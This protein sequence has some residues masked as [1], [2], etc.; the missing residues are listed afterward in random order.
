MERKW[1]W[2]ELGER[3]KSSWKGGDREMKLGFR[4]GQRGFTLIELMV[5]MAIL[6]VLAAVVI[7]AVSGTTDVSEDASVKSDASAVSTAMNNY[8]ADQG[9][10]TLTADTDALYEG[11][12]SAQETSSSWPEASITD[13]YTAEFVDDVASILIKDKD[14]TAIGD[15]VTAIVIADSATGAGD[16]SPDL[17][18]TGGGG[19]GATGTATVASGVVTDVT[20]TA[21]GSG[22]TSAPVVTITGGDGSANLVATI[23]DVEAFVNDRTAMDLDAA[24]FVPDYL[25]STPSSADDLDGTATTLHEY[26]WLAQKTTGLDGDANSSRKLEVYQLTSVGGDAT[27]GWEPVYQQIY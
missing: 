17:I 8:Y 2:S 1:K 10:E 7:P 15:A 9:V 12:T 23:G 5:V 3:I 22:Y 26:L 19:T 20:L 4:R 14:G 21:G 13:E 24:D 6:A 25:V 16:G 27:D 18:F 11:T